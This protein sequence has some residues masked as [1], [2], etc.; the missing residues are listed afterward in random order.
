MHPLWDKGKPIPHIGRMFHLWCIHWVSPWNSLQVIGTYQH[1]VMENRSNRLC[2]NPLWHCSHW[3]QES[4]SHFTPTQSPI[5]TGELMVCMPMAMMLP[6]PLCYDLYPLFFF[7]SQLCTSS[8][9]YLSSDSYISWPCTFISCL[10]FLWL[11]SLT[12]VYFYLMPTP[13]WLIVP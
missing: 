2:S 10:S 8:H 6:T 12:T 3:R 7:F 9:G 5:L 13:L 11:I 1:S 4:A